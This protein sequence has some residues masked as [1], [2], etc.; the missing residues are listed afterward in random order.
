MTPCLT[1][2]KEWRP[3]IEIDILTE[4]L[5]EPIL[6]SHS[7]VN[8]LF[9]LPTAK[10]QIKRLKARLTMIK[11]LRAR[12][13]DIAFNLHGGSTATFLACLSGAKVSIG[14]KAGRYSR[15]LSLSA[16][17]P[18]EIW[19]KQK[20]HCVEQQLGLL[21]WAGIPIN[22]APELN[23]EVDFETKKHLSQKLAKAKITQDFIVVHPSAAFESKE[24]ESK[25]FVEVIEYLYNFYKLPSVI[26]VAPNEIRVANAIKE[27]IKVPITIFADLNLRELMALI[28][29]SKLF[30]GNDS[31]PAHI[32]AGFK[33]PLVVIFGSSNSQVWHPWSKE[34]YK[35]LKASLPCI[36]CPGYS[37]SEFP[38]PECIKQITVREV[39]LA[40]DDLL[41]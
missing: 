32:A 5:S 39:I 15:L 13:Y 12:N 16:P 17:S 14:Y 21:K 22:V 6:R 29:E 18:Q 19:Q 10:S 34:P 26:A 28:S 25:R 35:L 31:G 2:L 27:K 3:E 33:K 24:W 38:E 37:C 23:L 1:T 20:I 9:V 8:N 41:K 36:P 11:E 30:L 40:L 4:S 7:K